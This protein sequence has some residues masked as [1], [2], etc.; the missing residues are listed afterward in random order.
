MSENFEE[1]K[2]EEILEENMTLNPSIIL[3]L[4]DVIGMKDPTNEILNDQSFLIDYIDDTKM[5][6][7]RTSDLQRVILTINSDGSIGDGSINEIDILYRNDND[8][9]ARQNGLLTGEWIDIYFDGDIPLVITGQIT[10]L[11]GD[12]IEITKYPDGKHLYINFDYKGIPENLPISNISI[13]TQPTT[14]E[15]LLE[16]E[17]ER[18]EDKILAE[19]EA[20]AIARGTK[21][22]LEEE[23]TGIIIS[24]EEAVLEGDIEEFVDEMEHVPTKKI[25]ESRRKQIIDA[26][27]IAS[28]IE[29][30]EML[31]EVTES[32]YVDREKF[33]F[34]IATQANDMLEDMLASV[35]PHERTPSVLRLLHLR[36]TRFLQLRE[37]GSDFDENNNIVGI[38][39]KGANAKYKPLVGYLSQLQN[40]LYW[41]LYITK[42]KR[43]MYSDNSNDICEYS[44]SS[45][46]SIMSTYI[47]GKYSSNIP[48]VVNNLVD[49][50]KSMPSGEDQS[51]YKDFYTKMNKEFT[52]FES[53]DPENNN[54]IYE[55]VV[56]N[57]ISSI[58]DVV[59]NMYGFSSS[60]IITNDKEAKNI[61]RAKLN[62]FIQQTYN[63]SLRYLYSENFQRKKYEPVSKN[64]TQNDITMVSSMLTLPEPTVRFSKIK[65]PE[66]TIMERANLNLTYLNYWQLLKTKT[67]V[68]NITL[69]NLNEEYNYV[70]QVD[71]PSGPKTVISFL[72][73]IKNISVDYNLKSNYKN[74]PDEFFMEYLNTFIPTTKMLFNNVKKY[75]NGKLSIVEVVSYLEP[76]MVYTKDL[77]FSQYQSIL[78]FINDKIYEYKKEYAQY[79]RYFN[80]F[81][82]MSKTIQGPL[83]LLSLLDVDKNIKEQ[84]K[85]S[86][87]I[88]NSTEEHYLTNS[89]VLKKIITRDYGDLYNAGISMQNIHLMFPQQLNN[90]LQNQTDELK[91]Q[92]QK[93][94]ENK[95]SNYIIAKRYLNK[96]ELTKDNNRDTY[97]DKIFDKTPY[98]VLDEPKVIKEQS[99]LG[100]DQFILYLVNYLKKDMKMNDDDATYTAESLIV[101]NK[102]VRDGQYAVLMQKDGNLEYYKRENNKWELNTDVSDMAETADIDILCML[103]EDCIYKASEM[104]GECKDSTF[105]KNTIMQ[106]TLKDIITQF[107]KEYMLTTEELSSKLQSNLQYYVDIFNKI[108][109]IQD[110]QLLKYNDF[111]YKLGLTTLEDFEYIPDEFENRELRL[112]DLIIGQQDFVKKQNDILMFCN[113]FTRPPATDVYNEHDESLESPHWLYSTKTNRQILPIFLFKLAKAYSISPETY[114]S[115]IDLVVKECGVLSSDGDKRIDKNTGYVIENIDFD[116]EEGYEDGFKIKSRDILEQEL[117]DTITLQNANNVM[118][119]AEGKIIN[120]MITTLSTFMGINIDNQKEFII[121]TIIDLIRNDS[122]M[123]SETMYNKQIE[124]IGKK[125]PAQAQKIPP[126]KYHFNSTLL[127]LTLGT[128]VIAVQ[129][130]IPSIRTKKVFPGCVKSFTGY[131]FYGEGDDSALLYVACIAKTIKN[132]APWDTIKSLNTDKIV[133]RIKQVTQKYLLPTSDVKMKFKD[134]EVY[135]A[136]NVDLEEIP[137]DHNISLWTNFLPPLR[138]F[139]IQRLENIAQGYYSELLRDLKTGSHYQFDKLDVIQSKIMQFSLAIQ[140]AIQRILDNKKLLMGSPLKPYMDNACCNEKGITLT[141]LQY[142]NEEN[143]EIGNYN[144]IV[145]E[146]S[147]IL[148]DVTT[149][150]K[151]VM[152]FYPGSTKPVFP[153]TT[154]SFSEE[155]IYRSFIN[156]CNF[157]NFMPIPDNLLGLCREKPDNINRTESIQ[158]QILKLKNDG[159]TYTLE[160]FLSLI[161]IVNRNNI[162]YIPYINETFSRIERLRNYMK[163][164]EDVNDKNISKT[165]K[166]KFDNLLDTFD[167]SN[168]ED[169][170]EMILM[171]KYLINQ[172][173]ALK[174]KVIKFISDNAKTTKLQ[175]KKIQEFFNNI[176]SWKFDEDETKYGSKRVTNNAMSNANNFL[177]VFIS[178][179]VKVYPNMLLNN[180]KYDYSNIITKHYSTYWGLSNAHCNDIKN[181]LINYYKSFEPFAGK[182]SL[183]KIFKQIQIDCLNYVLLSE[184]TP[185]MSDIITEQET[186]Y[187]IFNRQMSGL[188]NE[189]YMYEVLNRYIELSN[190]TSMI[191]PMKKE[192]EF[193]IEFEMELETEMLS[194]E[195][196]GE[197]VSLKKDTAN[198]LVAYI[199]SMIVSKNTIN[200]TLEDINDMVFK[201]KEREKQEF[202]SKFERLSEEERETENI[203]KVMKLGPTWSKG[204]QAS[205]RNYDADDYD[206]DK[207]MA[208]KLQESEERLRKMK[209]DVDFDEREIEDYMQDEEYED[210]VNKLIE[211]DEFNLAELDEDYMDGDYYNEDNPDE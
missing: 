124:E 29:F 98:S 64:L 147:N 86:Y 115:A 201:N 202:I 148:N 185:A 204:L 173:D 138:D 28:Q 146:L 107:D 134:K 75:I 125:N 198:L 22:N 44:D 180:V 184:E 52:P 192:G 113:N 104:E 59:D 205:V 167:I 11:E 73:N 66:T 88:G 16:E 128:Y 196:T 67:T 183:S 82:T 175:N 36:I 208:T 25:T 24:P 193:D 170:E 164:L 176:N 20:E 149:I 165:F 39:T 169:P 53:L 69:D 187:S 168:V 181:I 101:G 123:P 37:L 191:A 60:M 13:R 95:C 31:G 50:Y 103:Q 58:V 14:R 161:Q 21:T 92:Q 177:K 3:K 9:Y 57:N 62:R 65:L 63:T 56:K 77:T 106:K 17:I 90:I 45:E 76:F 127:Y 97:F 130:S 74:K 190:N 156:F 142:F 151:S 87:N 194:E 108:E 89:E 40:D 2:E 153:P 10:N 33:R 99:V 120:G 105:V 131:P 7:I 141:T 179:M 19:A 4:G 158:E 129:T 8:G 132:P 46:D 172:N 133:D 111:Q 121:K 34:D 159:N 61:F 186:R 80:Y 49:L 18:A 209:G 118:T 200:F 160:Q 207:I 189:Y 171:K 139:K 145:R 166:E 150:T 188:M 210:E 195:L 79:A 6:L 122:V 78:N 126:Y 41:I 211:E 144:N 54:Y 143:P 43:I 23:P 203:L 5:K 71:D 42:M 114:R 119:T 197:L 12:M 27:L 117:G 178:A 83:I 15:T 81:R 162:I 47:E 100:I 1:E 206:D 93:Q 35:P 155:T 91:S 26:D 109:D 157:T 135:L 163:Y 199:Q 38:T 48:I 112:R 84:I 102:K 72:N 68:E 85:E 51:R 116:V 174:Q 140:E 137:D 30:G 182:S 55:G 70:R 110:K 94:T 32:V 96:E 154:N 152:I 136:N